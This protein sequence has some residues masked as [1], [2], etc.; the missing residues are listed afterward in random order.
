M[1]SWINECKTDHAQ[2]P[3]VTY[4]SQPEFLHDATI[5]RASSNFNPLRLLHIA[6][7]DSLWIV[8]LIST[9]GITSTFN[10]YVALSYCWGGDQPH[11]TTRESLAKHDGTLDLYRLPATIQDACKVTHGLGF[12][13]LWVDS[14]CI[15]QDDENE[16]QK[17]IANMELIYSNATVTISASRAS[18]CTN[19]FLQPRVGGEFPLKMRA[20][21]HG[22]TVHDVG[23]WDRNT[24]LSQPLN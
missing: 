13:Y 4:T 18:S 20:K 10:P 16:K 2:P 3:H 24:N 19:G 11:K 12:S 21:G 9:S 22:G 14:L 5:C 23:L 17:E 7:I 8:S 6:V 15:V 1:R